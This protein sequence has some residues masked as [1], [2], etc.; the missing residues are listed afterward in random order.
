MSNVYKY[1]S[2]VLENNNIQEEYDSLVI[3]EYK[4]IIVDEILLESFQSSIVR[5]VAQQIW[6]Y[7]EGHRKDDKKRIENYKKWGWRSKP[8]LNEK[9]F[10][11]FF[12]PI[13]IGIKKVCGVKWDTIK[14]S[15]F[16]KY[17]S[18]DKKL[19]KIIKEVYAHKLHA[20]IIFCE[21]DTN[22]VKFFIKG[23]VPKN[24]EIEIY[25]F[26]SKDETWNPGVFK[27][28]RQIYK[29]RERSLK[30]WEA[31]E[32]IESTNTDAYVLE[33]TDKMIKE[34]DVQRFDRDESQKDVIYYDKAWL[35]NLARTQRAKY[36]TL[37]EEIKNKK[38]RQQDE[39]LFNDLKQLNQDIIAL[40]EEIMNSSENVD[41]VYDM[42]YAMQ[43]CCEA[44][45][46]YYNYIK[47]NR[48]VDKFEEENRDTT[49]KRKEANT[50]LQRA[51]DAYVEA[52][53]QYDALKS[54]I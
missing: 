49:W 16:V 45:K 20:Y 7:E 23:Y 51:N 39:K 4:N 34:Y 36:K 13:N 15:D 37:S 33:I 53:K 3:E 8:S 52:K 1:V 46:Y 43:Y 2:S 26:I 32:F 38:L 24:N 28:T 41:K 12:S 6:K 9:K 48:F 17:S 29:N 5:N 40:Q 44:F 11:S 22:N 35:D 25:S 19:K 27:K 10:S 54:K 50:N 14:D 31:Q 42:G 30:Q 18:D 47:Q 21:K